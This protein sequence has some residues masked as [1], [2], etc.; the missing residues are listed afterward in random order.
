M[1][2]QFAGAIEY[3][4]CFLCR[5]VRPFNEFTGMTLNNLMVSFQ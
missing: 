3:T 2:G 4:D 1:V 5:G